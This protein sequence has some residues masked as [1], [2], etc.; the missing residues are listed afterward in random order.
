MLT[1]KQC[2]VQFVRILEFS[3]MSWLS[4]RLR[5]IHDRY[6]GQESTWHTWRLDSV[7]C[8][9]ITLLSSGYF[10]I[11]IIQWKRLRGKMRVGQIQ[12]AMLEL[13]HQHVRSEDGDECSIWD[14]HQW[15]VSCSSTSNTW[16][17]N[18]ASRNN[19]LFVSHFW[20][21]VLH[22]ILETL[23]LLTTI[24]CNFRECPFKHSRLF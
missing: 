16:R 14:V 20:E 2:L 9:D 10:W 12:Q 18:S 1:V 3:V 23:K 15:N 24:D 7:S 8:F 6:N 22:V 17:W 5:L 4:S 21:I 11:L 19:R 13:R